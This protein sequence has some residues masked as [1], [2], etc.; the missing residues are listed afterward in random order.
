MPNRENAIE[1]LTIAFHELSSAKKLFR[2]RHFTD[3]IGTLTQQA[4]EKMLKSILAYHNMKIKKSHDLVEIYSLIQDHV[5][6]TNDE[7]S[8]LERATDYYQENRYPG[9]YYSLPARKEVKEILDFSDSL[10]A[11]LCD[12][13]GIDQ[14]TLHKK[15]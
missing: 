13:F 2:S 12:S 11:K 14:K 15:F 10:L 1:W 6:L 5:T 7:I 8:R 3:T 9:F 4:I